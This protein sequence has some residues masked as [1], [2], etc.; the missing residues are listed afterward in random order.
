MGYIF[1]N[2]VRNNPQVVSLRHVW[3]LAFNNIQILFHH[4]TLTN[5]I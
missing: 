4:I 1:V 2:Q 5:P 3:V